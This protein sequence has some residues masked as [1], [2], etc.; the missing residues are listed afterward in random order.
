MLKNDENFCNRWKAILKCSYDLMLLVI[1]QS[2]A[3]VETMAAETDT[4]QDSLKNKKQPKEYED[5]LKQLEIDLDNFE[6]KMRYEVKIHK[7]ERGKKDYSNSKVY[8]WTY[9]EKTR[10]RVTSADSELKT[11]DGD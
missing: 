2:M 11:T 8:N 10:K 4:L 3:T 1:E 5:K 6:K 9:R 7:F